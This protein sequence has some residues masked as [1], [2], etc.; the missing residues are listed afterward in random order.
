MRKTATFFFSLLFVFAL[1]VQG[2]IATATVPEPAILI[3]PVDGHNTSPDWLSLEW[4]SGEGPI[5]YGYR[6]YFG[7]TN[8]P[9]TQVYDGN[10]TWYS[11]QG[12]EHDKEYF[13][14]VVPYNGQGDAENV[15][16]WSFS[17]FDL[18]NF[19]FMDFVQEYWT[20]ENHSGSP[21]QWEFPGINAE[22]TTYEYKSDVPVWSTMTSTAIDCS[23]RENIRLFSNFDFYLDAGFDLW[24]GRIEISTDG[25][26]WIEIDLF[27]GNVMDGKKWNWGMPYYEYDIS[28][29][30]DNQP[31]LWIR[32][33]FNSNGDMDLGWDVEKVGLMSSPTIGIPGAAF[34]PS[35]EDGA[36]SAI[37]TSLGWSVPEDPRPTG[38]K[39]Y[40]GMNN[41]PDSLIYHGSQTFISLPTLEANQKFYWKVVPYND[42]GEAEDVV[43]WS[44]TTYVFSV[45]WQ[46]EFN[47][48]TIDWTVDNH[49]GSDIEWSFVTVEEW[50]TTRY[51]A[52]IDVPGDADRD[53]QV[54]SSLT[55]PSIDLSGHENVHL[56]VRNIFFHL[57]E[58]DAYYARILV[59]VDNGEWVEVK[60]YEGAFPWADE[61][62]GAYETFQGNISHIADDQEN[63]K[64]RLEFKNNGNRDFRWRV[65]RV[66]VK[67]TGAYA[68][69]AALIVSPEDGAEN[70]PV[71]ATLEWEQGEGMSASGYR[72]YFDTTNPPETMVAEGSFTT[73]DLNELDHNTE[74]F[75]MVVPYNTIGDAED[76]PVWS[77]STGPDVP[78]TAILI[79]PEDGAENQPVTLALEWEPGE[80]EAA[81]G[82]RVYLDTANPPQTLIAEGDFTTLV[83]EDLGYNTEFFWKVV[84]YN[85]TG[86]AENVATWS[87]TTEV[88]ATNITDPV[89]AGLKIFPNPAGSQ[90]QVV[91]ADVITEVRM[92]DLL[93]QLV[94]A[95]AINS[96]HARINVGQLREGVYLMQ[97]HTQR[98]I[99]THRV[100]VTR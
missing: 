41:E 80:G 40:M 68:P 100:Q 56:D 28:H 91:A 97:V 93:G 88:D 13:W 30:A 10:N 94:Y 38:Y 70:Q 51:F 99:S 26:N 83:V 47:T 44:F 67:S 46:E 39:V 57:D 82:Y 48:E 75:W 25:E 2:N 49:S 24:Y 62:P 58:F 76:V 85:V 7:E 71:N 16:V 18:V 11:P 12:L 1:A 95:A 96:A 81:S 52:E 20:V 53:N 32:Y 43:V 73:Y 37:H 17:T 36:N 42:E 45:V 33:E 35:P 21:N 64:I 22:I 15:P 90:L 8:P 29:I 72:L 69:E 92:Y 23:G 61:G 3:S 55:S 6:V 5:P 98:G 60:R 34:Y 4:E 31:Q 86:D 59:S 27:E 79:F 66:E 19:Y 54:W 9:T 78:A 65:F 14:M 63:V 77:F 89:A 87:F 50:G 74:Y 84:P